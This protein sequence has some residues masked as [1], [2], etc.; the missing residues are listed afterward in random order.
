MSKNKKIAII[1]VFSFGYVD[2]L[3]DRLNAAE[4]VDLTYINVDL[5]AFSYKNI[6]SR[7]SNFFL[8]L[9]FNDGL[10]DRSK[11]KY[12]KELIDSKGLFDQ[13]LIIRHDKIQ[14]EALRYLRG[15]TT[16]MTCFLFD[17][18]EN[19]KEQKNTLHYFDTVYSYDRNDV[20]KY[21][22]KFLTNYIYDDV[23]KN[24]KIVQTVFNVSSF[25]KRVLFLEK[26]ANYLNDKNISFRFILRSTKNNHIENI[27]I[28][29]EYLPLQEVKKIIANSLVL[30][31]IQRGN[32]CG[33]SF[34]VFEAL[35]YQKKLITSNTDIVNYDFYDKN[36]IFVVSESNYKIPTEF[37]ETEYKPISEEIVN[38]Y[39]I[40][41]WILQVF[42]IKVE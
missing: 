23:I 12:I 36:N 26:L 28:I 8:K 4:N 30:V 13:I 42:K 35:G 34:R 21:N 9:I 11:T 38:E 33:L 2:F 27:E 7:I 20:E 29:D 3:V 22:F 32:Q 37:F 15:K 40:N 41:S 39:K 24:G 17:G 10:K 18:I 14:N 16:E 6:F 19:Y 5:V 1:T 25:D 31:D